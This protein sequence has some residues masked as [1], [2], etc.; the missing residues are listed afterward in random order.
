MY[1]GRDLG[2]KHLKYLALSS[3]CASCRPVVLAGL[4]QLRELQYGFF[5][6]FFEGNSESFSH[7]QDMVSATTELKEFFFQHA[8][9]KELFLFID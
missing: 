5:M 4:H 2:P 3:T 8:F 9:I 7:L 6:L 1:E